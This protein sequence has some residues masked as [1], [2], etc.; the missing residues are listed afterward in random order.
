M[1]VQS[2]TQNE[3]IQHIEGNRLVVVKFGAPWCGPCKSLAPLL[4]RASEKNPEIA[5]FDV[6]VEEAPTLAASFNIRSLPTLMA[7]KDGGVQWSRVGLPSA[8]DLNKLLSDLSA[9]L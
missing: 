3:F 7:W 4:D 6:N 5:F 2:L 1:S 9:S 8:S